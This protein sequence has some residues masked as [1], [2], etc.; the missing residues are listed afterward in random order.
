[1]KDRLRQ[2]VGSVCADQALK[3]RTQAAVYRRA[4]R[5][6]RPRQTL[7]WAAAVL[8]ALVLTIGLSVYFTPVSAICVN[9]NPSLEL[10]VNRFDRVISVKGLN[11]DGQA[12]AGELNLQFMEYTGAIEALLADETIQSCLAQ[13]KDM[14]IAVICDDQSQSDRMLARLEDCTQGHE[15]VSCHAGEEGSHSQQHQER[16]QHQEH[17]GGHHH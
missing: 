2:A 9:I 4:G 3:D 14:S 6:H 12:L 16:Q 15:N 7:R 8:C 1:M 5:R 10:K 17:H 13:G 11:P